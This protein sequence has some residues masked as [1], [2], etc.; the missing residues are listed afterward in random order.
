MIQIK[1]K[2]RQNSYGLL[3]EIKILPYPEFSATVLMNALFAKLHRALVSIK[4]DNLG[5]SF[6]QFD[7]KNLGDQL[8]L[9]GTEEDL[10]RLMA[11][12][13]IKGLRDYTKVS[14]IQPIPNNVKYRIVK[15]KQVKSNVERL[16]RRSVKKSQLTQEEIDKKFSAFKEQ[17]LKLPYLQLQS[18]S[19]SQYFKLFISHGDLQENAIPENS[20]LMD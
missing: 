13:W 12:N 17:R 3:L 1:R 14:E 20:I 16:K 11:M 15:R 18:S 2:M 6:P 4:N 19:T 10:N 5:I 7:K 9:H 8:R